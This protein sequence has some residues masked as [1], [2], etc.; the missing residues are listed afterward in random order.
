MGRGT[1]Q[2]TVHRATRVRHDWVTKLPP[3]WK[4]FTSS[5][6]YVMHDV[7]SP[8]ISSLYS[9]MEVDII[10]VTTVSLP[11]LLATGLIFFLNS[12]LSRFVIWMG[13]PQ[14]PVPG[15]RKRHRPKSAS[16]CPVS[17]G[18]TGLGEPWA[19]SLSNHSKSQD[20]LQLLEEEFF[21]FSPSF[22]CTWS[23]GRRA[24]VIFIPQEINLFENKGT[25][26]REDNQEKK[27]EKQNLGDG[28]RIEFSYVWKENYC[29]SV[30]VGFSV[31]CNKTTFTN[32]VLM[33]NKYTTWHMRL[34]NKCVFH[35]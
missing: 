17:G 4:N 14:H 8:M 26:W 27:R 23:V 11:V 22:F 15:W 29:L 31:I 32:I 16:Y 28:N 5:L 35:R 19:L 34:F 3:Y 24:T 2:A 10:F 6:L 20:F 1:W 18:L 33:G 21:S 13:L 12:L 7:V 9:W 25:S 30:C